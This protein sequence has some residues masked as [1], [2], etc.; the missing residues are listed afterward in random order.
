MFTLLIYSGFGWGDDGEIWI[1]LHAY[2]RQESFEWW[3]GS[4]STYR[5]WGDEE[6]AN[7]EHSDRGVVMVEN[8]LWFVMARTN[9]RRFIC[10]KGK[11][12]LK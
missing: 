4:D 5:N 9:T 8:G 7:I 12:I 1:G 10:E 2:S 11:A 3:D 6:P